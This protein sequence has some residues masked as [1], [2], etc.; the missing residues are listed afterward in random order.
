MSSDFLPLLHRGQLVGDAYQVGFLLNASR[1][2]QTYRVTDKAGDSFVLR[3][4]TE[5]EKGITCCKTQAALMQSCNHS[6]LPGF[7]T[8]GKYEADGQQYYFLI[9][10]HISGE[11]LSERL[12]RLGSISTLT[13]KHI[14]HA[15]LD[16]LDS[17]Q[18]G[19]KPV[20][21]NNLSCH[22]IMINMA[23][24]DE[25][26]HLTDLDRAHF[27]DCYFDTDIDINEISYIATE[28]ISGNGTV[29]SDLFSVGVILY[30]L[31][32]GSLPWHINLSEFKLKSASI[33]QIVTN[34]RAAG[35]N[36]PDITGTSDKKL[37]D[38]V[39]QALSEDPSHRFQTAKDFI[40][41]LEGEI[42][43]R[44]NAVIQQSVTKS[45]NRGFAAI[46]GMESLKETIK[47]DVIDA[48]NDREKYQRYGLDIPNG[49]LLYGPPG[50]GKTFFAER[51]AEEVG[52]RLF[53]LKPSDIQSKWVNATQENIKQLFDNARENAPSIIF[54]DELDAIVPKRDNDH[55]NHMNTSAVNEFLAQMNNCGA[56]GI[57]IVGATNKPETI[58]PAIMRTGRIDK[59]IYIP[60]PDHDSRLK[61]FQKLLST[62]PIQNDVNIEDL[63]LRTEYYMSSD[64]KFLCDEAARSAL[65]KNQYISQN[66]LIASI[67]NNPPSISPSEL[68][69]YSMT[70]N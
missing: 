33:Q 50:C 1:W 48:L 34:A 9:Q 54:I 55:V 16:G 42:N 23:S 52:F 49:M 61:L 51:M 29:Q 45:T 56:D 26:Y 20:I 18:S 59:K 30:R 53:H 15:I 22:T 8:Q 46:A 68:A 41:A 58:D 70:F 12:G 19:A 13:A 21:C 25:T 14:V 6:F 57:F 47:T 67:Q 44:A 39:Q 7:V 65:K 69:M 66:D 3:L 2:A 37:F 24:K 4:F 63:A 32:Y 31:L 40:D 35:I 5:E 64:I 10:K 36:S 27:E 62:R 11:L 17:L 43:P 60:P 28:V 38:V